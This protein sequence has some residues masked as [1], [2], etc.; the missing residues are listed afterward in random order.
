MNSF[1][2]AWGPWL[3]GG[4]LLMIITL[5]LSYIARPSAQ[6]ITDLRADL[7]RIEASHTRDKEEMRRDY[8]REINSV[9]GEISEARREIGALRESNFHLRV[10][11]TALS[12]Q[13]NVVREDLIKRDPSLRILTIQEIVDESHVPLQSVTAFVPPTA[14]PAAPPATP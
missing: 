7:D 1:W 11:F 6:T 13:Y 9:R 5:I 12:V 14:S 8:D 3:G 10:V 4:G 2:N